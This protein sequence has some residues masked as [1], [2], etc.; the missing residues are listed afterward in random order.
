MSVGILTGLM[1]LPFSAF[2]NHWVGIFHAFARTALVLVLWYGF[3]DLR[4]VLIPFATVGVYVI[5]ITLLLRRHRR[6]IDTNLAG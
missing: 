4:F 5:T 3:P 6:I 1:W 2:I